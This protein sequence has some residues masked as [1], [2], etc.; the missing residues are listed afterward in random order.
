MDKVEIFG[1]IADDIAGAVGWHLDHLNHF[2]SDHG[3][4]H[5]RPKVRP[6]VV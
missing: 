5:Q 4:V 1:N 2:Y 6:R 3:A